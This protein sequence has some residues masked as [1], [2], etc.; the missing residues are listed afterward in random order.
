M[1]LYEFGP[2]TRR[3]YDALRDQ[4]AR[5]ELPPRAQLPPHK[6]LAE[7]FGVAPMT[8]RQVLARLE[9]EGL[10]SRQVGRGTFVRA[11]QGPN[12]LIAAPVQMQDLL[13]AQVQRI[14][15]AAATTTLGNALAWLSQANDCSLVVAAIGEAAGDIS[16]LSAIRHRWPHVH[17]AALVDRLEILEPLRGTPDCP[18]LI[19][20]TPPHP[21]AIRQVVRLS[22][23]SRPTAPERP[24]V[25]ELRS[26]EFQAHLLDAVDQAIIATRPDGTVLYWNGAAERMYGWTASEAVGQNISRLVIAPT[27]V[28]TGIGIMDQLR[29]G[30]TWSGEFPV[31]RRDGSEFTAL[32][33]DAPVRA[34]DGTLIG[35]I[36]VS[37]DMTERRRAE[38]DR[39]VLARIEAALA[40]GQIL[41]Q[42]QTADANRSLRITPESALGPLYRALDRPPIE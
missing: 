42:L 37:F 6:R 3:I 10:V 40:T 9:S 23:D 26:L 28:A 31:R 8:V 36:G 19:V 27:D 15:G 41:H 35:V 4:I 20:L 38:H 22:L 5:G 2:R 16:L 13:L 33:T 14:G 18:V 11:P 32:V 12:V 34:A 24:S 21:D 1:A 25:A 39:L 7:D 17:V 30:E 29:R